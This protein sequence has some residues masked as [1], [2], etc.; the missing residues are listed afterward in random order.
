[1][2]RFNYKINN[3]D[4]KHLKELGFRNI[5]EGVYEYQFAGYKWQ[6]FTTITCKFIAFD[7]NKDIIVDVLNENGNLYAPYYSDDN[8]NR[9]LAIIKS[10][11]TKEMKKCG[12][13]YREKI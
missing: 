10:N 1:M 7:D 8:D 11:I 12:I 13:E 5:G 9:V 3:N 2:R 6:G 4:I